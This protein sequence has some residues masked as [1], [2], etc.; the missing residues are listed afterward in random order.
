VKRGSVV[1]AF[2]VAWV[3][4]ALTFTGWC[5]VRGYDISFKQI[6][7]PFSYYT[8]TWPPSTASPTEYFPSGT[9]GPSPTP[10]RSA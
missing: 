3:A 6:W 8:G 4:Y 2:G 5:W 1:V 9:G 7:S 10:P